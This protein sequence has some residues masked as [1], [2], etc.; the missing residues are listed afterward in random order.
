M[1]KQKTSQ[2]THFIVLLLVV[3]SIA[4]VGIQSLLTSHAATPYASVEAESGNLS[5]GA[6]LY[7]DATASNGSA[8]KFGS[9]S[10]GNLSGL[11]WKSGAATVNTQSFANWRGRP[12]DVETTWN[13][14]PTWSGIEQDYSAASLSNSGYHGY[15]SFGQPLLPNDDNGTYTLADCSA[16]DYNTDFAEV[17]TNLIS[18]KFSGVD[19]RLGWEMNGN[20]YTWGLGYDS[21]GLD[22]IGQ[23]TNWIGCYRQAHDAMKAV[24]PTLTFDWNPTKDSSH[25]GS[26]E[27]AIA[28]YPGDSYV[29][30][31]GVD[32]YDYYPPS[33]NATDWT[34]EYNQ[35]QYSGPFGI[36]TWLAFAK[37]H[38]KNLS[39]PEW[40]IENQ[41]TYGTNGGGGDDGYYIG[42]MLQFFDENS[43]AIAYE[44]YFNLSNN[45]GC[46]FQIYDSSCNNTNSS[47]AYLAGMKQY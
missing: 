1:Y 14:E 29:D 44:S 15:V 10:S 23:E 31:I 39:V 43:P 21:G 33:G 45:Q 40:G 42:Q 32:Y 30:I 37:Q 34:N 20:W 3:I 22:N 2:P 35:T 7:T 5:S 8:V 18:D 11:P 12:L 6:K 17:A 16:G 41:G 38:T 46:V 19:V 28:E 24:Y 4:G 27:N 25:N 9:A 47:S 26:N 36:G 13:D